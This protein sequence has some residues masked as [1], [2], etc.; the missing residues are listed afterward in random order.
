MRY[1]LLLVTIMAGMLLAITA[2]TTETQLMFENNT[3]CGTIQIDLT[4]TQNNTTETYRV[5]NGE[6]LTIDVLPDVPYSYVIDYSAAEDGEGYTCVAIQ[7]GEV[8]VPG[9]ATTQYSLT[10]VT[11]TP[12][13]TPGG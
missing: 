9:G 6:T 2:C 12:A 8:T 7:R 5:P 11:P 3:V 4:N 1:R 10:A 13:A